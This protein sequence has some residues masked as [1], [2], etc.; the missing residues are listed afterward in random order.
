MCSKSTG[1]VPEKHQDRT[2]IA[3]VVPTKKKE[4]QVT[5]PKSTGKYQKSTG[6]A[7]GLCQGCLRK[8]KDKCRSCAQKTPKS[9]RKSTG[10]AP[11]LRQGCLLKRR[12]VQVMCSKSTGKIPEKHPD[13]TGIAPGVPTKKKESTG[14]VPK[15][16]RKVIVK[17]PGSHQ[18]CARGAS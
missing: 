12:E 11:G 5:C 1:K 3:P 14:H 18:D 7:R 13:R 10:I 16:H 15:K 8:R 6:I 2:G 17:A 9:Y 4:V